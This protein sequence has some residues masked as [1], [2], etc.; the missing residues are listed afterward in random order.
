MCQNALARLDVNAQTAKRAQWEAFEFRLTAGSVEVRNESH[1][2][3][4]VADHTYSVEVEDGVPV[5]CDC[6]ADEYQSGACKHRVAVA[7]REPLLDA[8]SEARTP[9]SA[10]EDVPADVATDGGRAVEQGAA[11]TKHVESPEQGGQEYARCT[12]CGR[13]IVPVGRFD[14]LAHADGC[15]V[16]EGV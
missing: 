16:E 9:A 14:K 15:S 5:A 13:E 12:G 3:G 11:Y 7:I 1:P 4:E 10:S 6:P 8:A 2:A